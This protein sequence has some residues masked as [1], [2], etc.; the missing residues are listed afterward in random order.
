MSKAEQRRRCYAAIENGCSL[1][2]FNLTGRGTTLTQICSLLPDISKS[3]NLNS[4][5]WLKTHGLIAKCEVSGY[6]VREVP[7]GFCWEHGLKYSD[8]FG[9]CTKCEGLK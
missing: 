7:P 9:I 1:N 8:M 2:Q 3:R 4:L 5:N 6:I